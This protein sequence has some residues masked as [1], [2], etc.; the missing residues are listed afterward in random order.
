MDRMRDGA[1][2][3]SIDPRLSYEN[4]GLRSRCVVGSV[5]GQ[6]KASQHYSWMDMNIVLTRLRHAS[7]RG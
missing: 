2:S 6:L 5:Q 1:G 4:R 3:R 7:C